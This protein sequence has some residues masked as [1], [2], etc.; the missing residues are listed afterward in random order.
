M[1]ISST[2]TGTLTLNGA[3]LGYQTF[4]TAG[5]ANGD[6]VSYCIEDGGNFEFGTGTYTSSGTTLSRTVTQSYNGTTYG[7]S[8]ISVT[9]NAQVFITALAADLT[10][11]GNITSGTLGV[12]NGGTGLSTLTAGYIPFGN[13]TSA[14]GNGNQ[15]FWDNTNKR[16]GLGSSNATSPSRTIHLTEAG[17]YIRIGLDASSAYLDIGRNSSD[18]YA[19]YNAA[20]ASPFRGHR[21]LNG[22]SEVMRIDSTGNVGIG[23]A[24]PQTT[25]NISG[26]FRSDAYAADQA[27]CIITRA[28]G[29]Q[30]SPTALTAGNIGIYNFFGYD[31]SA[32]RSCAYILAGAEQTVTSTNAPGFLSF[33]TTPASSITSAERMR[34]DSSGNIGINCTPTAKLD[35]Y[36]T[37]ANQAS[38][39]SVIDAATT[40]ITNASVAGIGTAAK[41]NL[42][43]ANI[44]SAVVE[45]YYAA[46]N[47]SNDIGVGL[48]FGTQTTAAGGVV[49][50]M[51][52]D[53]NG[54]VGIG[55]T[56]PS[57]ALDIGDGTSVKIIRIN[58][59]DSGTGGGGALYIG[60]AGT[61]RGAFGNTSALFGGTY[62]RQMALSGFNGLAFYTNNT[63]KVTIDTSGNVGI[64]TASPNVKL[65]VVSATDTTFAVFAGT[66][67][68][69]RIS[70]TATTAAIEGVD[71][72]GVASYQPLQVGGSALNFSIS[73]STKATLDSNFNFLIGS[74]AVRATTAGTAH[75]DIFNGTAP[76]GT[77]TNGISLY[78]SS[79]DFNFMDA[80]GN[81]YKVGF[82]NIPQV[83]KTGAYTPSDTSDVGK[84]ISI[85]T[86]GVTVNASIYSAGDVFTIYNNSGS[87]QT[88]TA[89]TNVTFRLAGTATT[90]NRTL[91][92]YGTATLLCVTGG[93]TPT[94]V[95]SGAGVT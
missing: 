49:E 15:F 86:G 23:V 25:L 91:A 37:V 30:A 27:R 63:E 31:G 76:A 10:S 57:T 54:N 62:T 88:I 26:N 93:A 35:V 82:R 11:A 32:Y 59:I 36:S 80:S 28:S 69:V 90:G 79:G 70:T 19:E 45:G 65:N 78:S 83:S 94:F 34:I 12:A 4:A 42:S 50:R 20:Q 89:G 53:H 84:H 22:G 73:G 39:M 61:T 66:A 16:L 5:V 3:V 60:L 9:T 51:R 48:A 43:I 87:N 21:F 29:T 2:G 74:T 52:L 55:T 13:G 77:L 58:A 18:G 68:A 56:S 24:S 46:F 47:G 40:R 95:V 41:L 17:P 64:G 81:G 6:V 92:Q 38:A 44:G 7:S 75:L 14:F 71:Q 1:S 72:T 67:R 8:P 33:A 85:T